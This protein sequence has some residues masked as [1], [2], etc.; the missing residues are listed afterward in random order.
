MTRTS[1]TESLASPEGTPQAAGRLA[2][3]LF[4]CVA[5]FLLFWEL[6]SR[7]LCTAEGR[8]AEVAR[9]MLLT[10]DF[11]HPTLHGMPYFD[12][13]LFSYW[14]IALVAPLTGLNEWALRIPSAVCGLAALWA[15]RWLGKRLFSETTGRLAGW[16]LLTSQG[17]LFWA[18]TGQADMANVAFI[19][20]AVVWYWR[21][22]DMPC[23]LTYL[24]FYLILFVGAQ[25]KGLTAVIVPALVIF[26]DLLREKRWKSLL[27]GPHFLALIAGAMVYLVPFLYSSMTRGDY[28]SSGLALVFQ[29]N[30][31]R[32]FNPF[33]H[34]EPFYA[35]FKHVPVLFLPWAPVLILA[36]GLFVFHSALAAHVALIWLAHIGM[37]RLLGFGIKYPTFFADTHLQHV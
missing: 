19:L 30:V 37:D 18:R 20:L 3:I 36:L 28:G 15:T 17:F 13:P 16:I 7:G 5:V 21:R 2:D 34:E 10:G 31:Q 24:V 6:G 35:Y 11:F 25:M 4:W 33:D 32:F 27:S 14:L 22:R 1:Y 29:E 8:W 9:E 12:K 26:P 23:F